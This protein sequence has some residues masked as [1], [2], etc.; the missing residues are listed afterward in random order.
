MFPIAS[1]IFGKLVSLH[2][3]APLINNLTEMGK[4]KN[5]FGCDLLLIRMKSEAPESEKFLGLV[6]TNLTFNLAQLS[7][8][9]GKI[10]ES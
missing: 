4:V 8:F 9:K 2:N 6:S 3:F 1:K 10:A 7:H 5:L